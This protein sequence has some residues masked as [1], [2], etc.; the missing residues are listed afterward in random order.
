[1]TPKAPADPG[2]A[3]PTTS[4]LDGGGELGAL[5]RA[6]DW[7]ATPLGPPAGWPQSLRSAVSILL[8]SKAQIVLFW[9]PEFITLYNDACRPVFGAKH[10]GALGRPAREAWSEIWESGLREL[11]EGVVATGEAVRARDRLFILERHGYPEE[12]YFD[13]SYDPVRDE[14]GNVDGL[15]CI[16]SETTGRVMGERRLRTLRDLAARQAEARTPE[17]ACHL[18]LESFAGNPQDIP[19]AL[20]YTAQHGDALPLLACGSPGAAQLAHPR[21]WPWSTVLATGEPEVVPLDPS[22]AVPAG[23]WARSPERAIVLPIAGTGQIKSAGILVVGLNPFQSLDEEYRGFLGLVAGQIGAGIASAQV[24]EEERARIE[25]LAQLDRAKTAFFSNISHEFRTPLTLMLGP[26]EETL[27]GDSGLPAEDRERLEATHRNAVRLLKLVNTLLDFSRLEAGRLEASFQPTDLAELTA[28]LAA[29]FRSAIEGAGLTFSVDCPPLDQPVYVDREMWEKVVL[30][31]ISNAFKFTLEGGIAVTLTREDDRAVLRVRDTG[32]GIPAGELPHLFERFHRVRGAR[33]R[34]IEGTGIGLAMVQELV[35]LHGGTVGVESEPNR[36][37]T[38]TVSLR[39]GTAHLPADRLRPART[40]DSEERRRRVVEALPGGPAEGLGLD[41]PERVATEPAADRARILLAEDN[42]DM[43]GYLRRVLSESY[44]VEAVADG[45]SALRAARQDPPD[46]VLTDVM[47]PELDGFGLLRELRND[48]RLR[49][50][51]VIMLSAR[52]GEE[53]RVEGM[54]SGADDY[55]VKPFS[56][57]E[58]LAR[59]SARLEHSRLRERANELIRASE[60]RYRAIFETAGASIWDEDFSAVRAAIEELKS[61]GV[62]DFRKYFAEHPEFVERA[63]GLVRIVN[64]NDTTL[65]MY[66]AA[67]K[68]E[69]TGSLHRIFLPETL[70]IFVEELLAMAEGKPGFEA[71]TVVSTLRGER[72]DVLFIIAFPP[73]DGDFQPALVTI[74]DITARKQAERSLRDLYQQRMDLIER[75]RDADRQKDEFLATLAHELRNPLAPLRNSLHLLRLAD[76]GA[77]VAAPIHE[78]MERQVSHM[79][80]LVDDLL[81]ISRI[82]RGTFE[83]RREP[84]ELA[85]VV[86]N[87]IE[88]SDPLIQAAGHELEVELPE[89]PLVVDGDP[90]RLAQVLS[91]VLNNSAKYTPP[92]GRISIRARREPGTAVVAVR[93]SGRGI[94][95]E[96]L[97]RLFEM[98]GRGAGSGKP[99]DGLGIG[100]ALARR[101]VEMHG[102]SIEAASGG[103][104]KGSEFTIRLPLAPGGSRPVLGAPLVEAM[105]SKRILVVDDNRDSAESMSMLLG[106]LGAEVRVALDGATALAIYQEFDPS[107]VLLDIGMPDMDGY[108]VARRIR[109][110]FPE[111]RTAI[112]AL[113]G[114]GQEQDRWRTRT[115]GFD[116][117]LTKPAD[118]EAL[119]ALVEDLGSGRQVPGR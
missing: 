88:T 61:R 42:P 78:M 92:G 25:S 24:H 18:S 72:L 57:R 108:E 52:A 37:S 76:G 32:T 66:G 22:I 68:A 100:L 51:P 40:H 103:P 45:R 63:V 98:F 99:D 9:G 23:A 47:M 77:G 67:D 104:G 83:L 82:T 30:N 53:A 33:G 55:L 113:T 106:V 102:G 60:S 94:S 69:L 39:V 114:W 56:G 21:H 65:R 35:R 80:R 5:M 62:T 115:A 3:A 10:P 1:M 11:F 6:F 58:L 48:E 118:I 19:F 27:A 43:R 38:F 7:S 95:P 117:H 64:V 86:R 12:T 81:E 111:R 13:F 97:P 75:L 41:L 84:V 31:L 46:L 105:S 112:V 50:V 93:D 36:G 109:A 71:E 85:T 107:V 16:V 8:S 101:L 70:P 89:E 59:V 26:L 73:P 49:A 14:S 54:D 29:V 90:V 96:V 28:E 2:R 17:E 116:H 44:D 74:M 91:N 119:Q 4:F 20:L 79:V 15:F 87:A 110:G 34:S